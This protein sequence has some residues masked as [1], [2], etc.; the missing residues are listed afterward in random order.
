MVLNEV[1]DHSVRNMFDRIAR[2][3]DLLNRIISFHLD[4]YWRNQAIAA[5]LDR[6]DPTLL[7]LGAGTGDLTFAALKATNGRARII[8]LDFSAQM[9]ELAQAKKQAL[10]NGG[11]T[12]FVW[13]AHCVHRSSLILLME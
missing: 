13:G 6:P 1:R 5:V 3:Y 11:K 12:S 7:D 9:L 4:A 8:G 10:A 2:R